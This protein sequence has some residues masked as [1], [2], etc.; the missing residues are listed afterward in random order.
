MN[1]VE[2]QKENLLIA[3]KLSSLFL[4]SASAISTAY[5]SSE[6]R[7]NALQVN[8]YF[9]HLT[10]QPNLT[11]ICSPVNLLSRKPLVHINC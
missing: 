2:K 7:L 4:T 8:S 10:M 3:Y 5:S 11:I 6:L 9:L 1:F